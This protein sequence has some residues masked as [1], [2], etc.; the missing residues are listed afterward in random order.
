MEGREGGEEEEEEEEEVKAKMVDLVS[1]IASWVAS[2]AR[3]V[4]FSF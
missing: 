2:F 4:S 1:F 3:R